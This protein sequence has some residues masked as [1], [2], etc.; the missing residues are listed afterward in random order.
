MNQRGCVDRAVVYD[1][2][3]LCSIACRSSFHCSYAPRCCW[4]HV[5]DRPAVAQPAPPPAPAP[6]APDR[7]DRIVANRRIVQ[8]ISRA[9]ILPPAPPPH[10]KR[11]PPPNRS[12]KLLP[13][14][15]RPLP[16]ARRLPPPE[17]LPEQPAKVPM[18]HRQ[19]SRHAGQPPV[20]HPPTTR[21]TIPPSTRTMA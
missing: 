6:T 17:R 12:R 15:L 11:Q 10:L 20:A 9:E 1:M 16:V 19:T 8:I 5:A 21:R 13:P 18:R 7:P 3:E 4:Q 14:P 2:E